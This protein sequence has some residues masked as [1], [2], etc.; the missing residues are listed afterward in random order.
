MKTWSLVLSPALAAALALVPASSARAFTTRVHIVLANDV[1]AALET[2]GDGTLRLRWSE[3]SVQLPMRDAE[4]IVAEPLAFRAG[5]IGPDNTVFPAM[6]D[7]THGVEQ[8]PYRQCEMLY[9]EAFTQAER[10]YAL[11]CFLHGATDAIAHHFVNHFTGETFTLN[12]ISSSRESSYDNVVGHIVTESTIQSAIYRADPGAFSSSELQ[13]E[14]PQDFVLRQYFDVDS[15]LWQ[16]MARHPVEKWE[17]AQAASPNG[18]LLS[19]AGSAGF[20]TWEHIAMAPRYIDELQRLREEL[21]VWMEARIAELATDSDI[22]AMPGPDARIGTPDDVTACSGGCPREYGEYWV[23]VHLLAPRFDTRGMPLPSA[24]DLISTDLGDNL[25]GFLPAFVQVIANVSAELNAG[26]TDGGDHGLDINRARIA[27]VFDPVDTWADETFSINWTAAGMAVT[28]EWYEAVSGFL[29]MLQV[30]IGIGDFL[31]QFFDPIVQQIRDALIA[32]VRDRAVAFVEELLTEYDLGR[33]RWQTQ[34]DE[35]LAASAPTALGGHALDEAL[36]SGLLAYAF[37]L[38]AASLA[39]HEV[40]LVGSD[41]IGNG[42][43]SF[44]ASYTPEWTQIGACDYLREAVFPL[45]TGLRPLLSVQQGASTYLGV[46]PTETP[47]ECHD[48]SL[49]SFGAPGPTSCAHVALDA[50]LVNPRGS[51]TRAYPPAHASGTP[52]CRG[53]VVPGLPPPPPQPDGGTIPGLDGGTTPGADGSTTPPSSPAGGCVCTA[54]RTDPA[55]LA[56][57]AGLALA[58]VIARRARRRGRR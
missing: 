46:V 19:W 25:Y 44:D 39:N 8:D 52:G 36:D 42:P 50:L 6:T 58:L 18:N 38:T 26:I 4:A 41:P 35:G 29:A 33:P 48:G 27:A 12:P 1:I 10:A 2:S 14:I 53:L 57:L 22:N 3:H 31:R 20:A 34:V 11:G 32:Q 28:P 5:A 24:F 23:L 56:S 30:S 47:I 37:N 17:A 45:G 54:G 55:P 21:R 40:L 9:Q 43:A 7:G 49:M 16:R 13:H 15:A 51:L